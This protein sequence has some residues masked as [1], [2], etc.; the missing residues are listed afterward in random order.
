MVSK[1]V[2]VNIMLESLTAPSDLIFNMTS[3]CQTKINS[4]EFIF[5]KSNVN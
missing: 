4:L 3:C 5:W 1:M 2:K